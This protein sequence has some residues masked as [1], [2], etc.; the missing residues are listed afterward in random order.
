MTNQLDTSPARLRELARCLCHE[1]G[2][3]DIRELLL[4]IAAE[5]EAEF[6]GKEDAKEEVIKQQQRERMSARFANRPQSRQTACFDL[7]SPPSIDDGR[8]SPPVVDANLK[9]NT[10]EFRGKEA[11]NKSAH[12]SFAERYLSDPNDPSRAQEFGLYRAGWA[13]AQGVLTPSEKMLVDVPLPEPV[14]SKPFFGSL[15]CGAYSADQMLAHREAYAKA[16]V[17]DLQAHSDMLAAALR[18]LIAAYEVSHPPK[19][20]QECWEQARKA[21]E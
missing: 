5:K 11:M 20:R 18:R 17:A 15:P 3:D 2:T 14:W 21:L 1:H 7:P 13:D 16:A 8:P 12:E 4:A 9:F 10:A 19:Q 6:R